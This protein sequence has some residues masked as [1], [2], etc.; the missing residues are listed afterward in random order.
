MKKRKTE[1]CKCYRKTKRYYIAFHNKSRCF[2]YAV[3]RQYANMKCR[4]SAEEKKRNYQSF[5]TD[6]FK[7]KEAV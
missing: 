4:I 7:Q 5:G 3:N 6:F 1:R 2:Y